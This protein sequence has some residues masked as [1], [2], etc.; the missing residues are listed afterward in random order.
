MPT[1]VTLLGIL[2]WLVVVVTFHQQKIEIFGCKVEN[3]VA[4]VV[5]ISITIPF[6]GIICVIIGYVGLIILSP[7]IHLAKLF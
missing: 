5:I 6:I 7:I 1:T 3:A 2:F 4:R